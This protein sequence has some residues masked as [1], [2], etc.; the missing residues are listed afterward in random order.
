M[1][2]ERCVSVVFVSLACLP[3][4]SMWKRWSTRIS[5]LQ[6]GMLEAKT[7]SD[8]CGVTTSRTRK[9]CLFCALFG[10]SVATI[11]QCESNLITLLLVASVPSL[12]C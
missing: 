1:L 7:R 8:H 4:A 11:L 5:A 3:Q 6:C 12:S 10:V 2:R 9:V